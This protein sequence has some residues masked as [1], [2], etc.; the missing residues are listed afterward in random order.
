MK[1][2][3]QG[4]GLLL[5]LDETGGELENMYQY[6]FNDILPK[7]DSID[8][9]II[10]K[11]YKSLITKEERHILA[12]AVNLLKPYFE[13]CLEREISSKGRRFIDGV[14]MIVEEVDYKLDKYGDDEDKILYGFRSRKEMDDHLT[15]RTAVV[16]TGHSHDDKQLSIEFYERWNKQGYA[17]FWQRYLYPELNL[18]EKANAILTELYEEGITEKHHS[19][20]NWIVDPKKL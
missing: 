11:L 10:K 9:D 8:G 16:A 13:Q 20:G 18:F 3:L 2:G 15:I 17:P 12:D 7:D 4:S 6:I 19:V 1:I 5:I 14:L